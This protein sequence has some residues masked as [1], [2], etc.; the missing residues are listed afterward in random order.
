MFNLRNRS[1]LKE[2][3]F[4]PGELRFLLEA[5]R[6]RSRPRSTRAPRSGASTARRSR[7]SSRRPRPGPGAAFE[8]AAHDQG[9]HVTYLDPIGLA[10]RSQGVDRRH[11]PGARAHVRRHRVPRRAPRTTSRS[12]PSS[13]G[14]PSTT[15]SPTSG[16][17]RRCSPTSSPC[18]RR[19]T[20]RTTSSCYAFVGD[21][22][23]N[24]GRSLL[25][26]GALMGADVRLAGPAESASRPADVVAIGQRDRRAHRRA[27]HRSPTTSPR[28]SPAPTS[29][30]PTSGCRWARP[31]TC[32]S[33]GSSCSAPYQVNRALL[34]ATGNPRGEVHA[35][36]AGVPRHQHRR[37]AP[38]SW[39]KTGMPDGPRGH[40]RGLRVPGQHRVRPGREPAPHHQGHP[41]R[42]AR[43]TMSD[44]SGAAEPRPD[45]RPRPARRLGHDPSG[46]VHRR[47]RRWSAPASS[48]CS[49]RRARWPAPRC[50][51]RSSSRVPS[52]V[53]QGYSFA[54]LG[55]R[56]PSAGGLMEYVGQS[57]GRRPPHRDRRLAALRGQRRR[58]RHGRRL[59]RQLRQ[60]DVRRRRRRLGR[61]CSP[62]LVVVAMT[63]AQRRRIPG[64]RPGPDDRRRSSSS[65]SSSLFAVDDARE[66][67][68]DL[69]A[70]SGL[71]AAQGHRVERR[72]HVLRVPRLRRH[73]LH[74][75]GPRATRPRQ[76]PRAM[77]LAL[78]IATIIYVARLARRV[79]HPHA[80]TR[81]STRAAPRS[82]SP[83]SRRSAGPATGS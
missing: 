31:R 18:T 67:R 21:C 48:R 70:P 77:Y 45:R 69:L 39:S 60:L 13:P 1:F 59:V 58:D 42:H 12:W 24:M 36:P 33:S 52:P 78:G 50:G 63:A 79:R 6:R 35:L 10:A 17:P 72:P 82:P 9:A 46:G 40:Q 15:G 29:S 25:V 56:Y 14:C 51:S 54:K 8:V 75:E 81:S 19:R 4:E 2:I 30:T 55:A 22:R 37:R 23:F 5:L 57:F 27:D 44:R 53:L 65:A 64:R 62:L 61:R 80:S 73:H 68:P 32:G 26:M 47:R 3:D 74:R 41:R 83:P 16:T 20:S 34:D 7:S 71:P 38:R 43:L 76:L 28:R 11:R 49:A 66:R